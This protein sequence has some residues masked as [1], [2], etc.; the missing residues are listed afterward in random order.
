MKPEWWTKQGPWDVARTHI[1]QGRTGKVVQVC[2]EE[3]IEPSGHPETGELLND[4]IHRWK[5]A[6]APL[7]GEI[8]NES[9]LRADS[10]V[11]CVLEYDGGP[12]VRMFADT[13]AMGSTAS[14]EFEVIGRDQSML[15]SS[16]SGGLASYH[17][18]K[19]QGVYSGTL[20]RKDDLAGDLEGLG[21]KFQPIRL[22]VVS[23]EH[24]HSTG[25][26]FPA[27][28]HI[29]HAVKVAAIADNDRQRCREH[30]DRYKANFY[31]TRDELLEDE[32][33]DAVLITSMNYNHAADAIAAANAG[34][35]VLCDK[36]IATT[37]ADTLSIVEAVRRNRVRFITTYPCRFHPAVLELKERIDRGELGEIQAVMGTNHGCM[38][39]PGTPEWVKDPRCNGGGSIIDHTVHVAD[40]MRFVTGKE[41]QDAQTFASS[42]LLGIQA[43]DIAVTHGRMTGGIVYQIDCSWSRKETDP[44]WGDFTM[45]IVGTKGSAGL[46]LYNNHKVEIYTSAG[47]EQR[48]IDLLC[49]QHGMIFLDYQAEKHSGR[50]GINADEIDGL[51]T[52]E[53]V[54]ASYQSL[55][56]GR[57]VDV[58]R[59]E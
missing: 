29:S 30:V 51:R 39:A 48:Y 17:C 2:L 59:N 45:R 32:N 19:D 38:Y 1:E 4:F 10:A 24:P 13:A 21:R 25:N 22:G 42:S 3:I 16:S 43:E 5:T 58:I 23:L 18:K 49:H 36:P 41:F 44:N 28:D 52:M 54:F 12:I 27:L 6:L 20:Y 9:V 15:Y 37:L 34:K 7:F 57:S 46:D 14:L 35:D 50:K 26:H 47:I 56:E 31:S 55:K 40:L 8:G 53:L 33:I 11:S